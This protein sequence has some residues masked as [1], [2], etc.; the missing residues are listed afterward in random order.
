[1]PQSTALR[2][3]TGEEA[4]APGGEAEEVNPPGD[5]QPVTG[6]RE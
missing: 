3:C 2:H 1:M 5:E 6:V 4:A